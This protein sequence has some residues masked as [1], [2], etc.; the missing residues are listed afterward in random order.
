MTSKLVNEF[1]N[2][3]QQLNRLAITP[4]IMGSVGLEMVTERDWQAQD[5]DI[6]V[7]GTRGGWE[8]PADR[9]IDQWESII[10][11][12]E[13]LDYQLV[14]LHEHKFVKD[15][16]SVGFASVNTLPEFAGIELRELKLKQQDELTYYVLS[17][18]QFLSVYLSS[19]K[20]SYRSEKNNNKDFKKIEYLKT[21]LEK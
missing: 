16:Y 10:S 11:V 14:D 8:I 18:E 7:P 13:T 15:E 4:L 5:I 17:L 20:D 1:L 3:A 19:S 12:M 21:I 9:Q 2:I 6:H